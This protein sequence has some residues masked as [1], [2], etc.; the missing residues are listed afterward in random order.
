MVGEVDMVLGRKGDEIF[1]NWRISRYVR[2][3]MAAAASN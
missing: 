2:I 3:Q 1:H